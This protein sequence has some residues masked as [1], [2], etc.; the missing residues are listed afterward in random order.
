MAFQKVDKTVDDILLGTH[1]DYIN[2]WASVH[3]EGDLY[4]P[5][6]LRNPIMK[7]VTALTSLKELLD[8]Y[9]LPGVSMSYDVEFD[10][11]NSWTAAKSVDIYAYPENQKE[12]VLRDMWEKSKELDIKPSVEETSKGKVIIKP[13]HEVDE[14]W[15]KAITSLPD[16]NDVVRIK[17]EEDAFFEY[18]RKV[19]YTL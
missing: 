12:S 5:K 11:W 7:K 6:V 14:D 1:V 13:Y 19:E 2:C 17:S 8:K 15:L 3:D 4:V 10:D 9:K 16:G 18:E